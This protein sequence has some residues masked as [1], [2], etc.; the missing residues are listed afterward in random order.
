MDALETQVARHNLAAGWTEVASRPAHVALQPHVRGYWGYVERYVAP[1][2]RRELPSADVVLILSFGPELRL[3]D[4]RDTTGR[5]A[6]HTSF[7]AGLT[8]ASVVTEMDGTSH[9]MQVNLTPLGAYTLLG[10]PMHAVANRVV[11]LED[12]LE[13]AADELLGRLYD[14]P[15][16]AERFDVL[17]SALAARL[18]GAAPPSPSVVWAWKR[19]VATDGRISVA[20]LAHQLGCSRN[21]LVTRFR[22]QVGLTPKASARILRFQRVLRLIESRSRPSWSE[23][24]L[25]CGYYDQAHFNRDFRQFAGSTPSQY[26]ARRMGDGLGLAPE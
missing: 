10:V 11:A 14:A 12:V 15:S 4:A 20:A 26:L 22:E 24:A 5:Q 25:D 23:I 1:M 3:L 19:L 21:H 2:R 18:A 16:W 7:V 6:A 9:G 17:D 13:R 8:E